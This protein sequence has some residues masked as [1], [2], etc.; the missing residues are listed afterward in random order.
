[1]PDIDLLEPRILNGVIER[2]PPADGMLGHSIVTRRP[3]PDTH[4][5]YDIITRRRNVARPNTPDSPAIIVDQNGVGQMSGS[6]IYTREKKVFSPTVTRWLRAPGQLA[7]NAAEAEILRELQELTDRVNRFEEMLIWKMLAEGGFDLTT[8]G[9]PGVAIDYQ[10]A[11]S[12]MPTVSV[13]WTNPTADLVGDMTDIKRI[14]TRDSDARLVTMYANGPTI[15]TL[16]QHS[17]VQGMLNDSQ[18]GAMVTE[19]ILPRFRSVNFVEYDRGYVD[20]FTDPNNPTF[21]T[22]IPDGY[23]IGIAEGGAGDRTFEYLDGPSADFGAPDGSTGRFAKTWQE[24][25]PSN[26]QGLLESNGMPVLYQPDRVV[27][28]RIF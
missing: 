19:G 28:V 14:V 10:I 18:R 4:W 9:H 5:V 21:R 13:F 23:L 7:A 27:I 2:M 8:L 24:E 22:Y 1:M 15:E 20:D 17:V 25:D 16:Y 26:R 6:F 3:W 11:A 12:H